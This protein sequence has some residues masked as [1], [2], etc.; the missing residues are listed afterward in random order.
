V[1][2]KSK[3]VPRRETMATIYTLVTRIPKEAPGRD[4]SLKE[5]WRVKNAVQVLEAQYRAEANAEQTI[6]YE[7]DP[8]AQQGFLFSIEDT[9]NGRPDHGMAA[10]ELVELAESIIGEGNI[11]VARYLRP[12][13]GGFFS[14]GKNAITIRSDMFAGDTL[15]MLLLRNVP[16]EEQQAKLREKWGSIV[17]VSADEIII[18]YVRRPKG[19]VVRVIRRNHT[20][21]AHAL[22]HE[23]GHAEDN[24]PGP[25]DKGPTMGR[26]RILGRIA[27]LRHFMG[28]FLGVVSADERRTLRRQAQRDAKAAGFDPKQDR[29]AYNQAVSDL[30]QNALAARLQE[31]GTYNEMTVG[32]I[33]GIRAE[34][35]ALTQWW[36][37]VTP[38][39]MD[40]YLK[41]G[42]E[43]YADMISVLLNQPEEFEARCPQTYRALGEFFAEHQEM[44]DTYTEI[45]KDIHAAHEG[46]PE[47][48][49]DRRLERLRR[50]MVRDED[51]RR[52]VIDDR[53][54]EMPRMSWRRFWQDIVRIIQA[55]DVVLPN[56]EA[57]MA[58]HDTHYIG[59]RLKQYHRDVQ[60]KVVKVLDD[61]GVNLAD[62][63]LFLSLRRAAFDEGRRDLANF[64]GTTDESAQ[65]ALDRMREVHG[66]QAFNAMDTAAE[67][68]ADIRERH[69]FPALAESGLV[70]DEFLAKLRANRY[71]STFQVAKYF[72]EFGGSSGTKLLYKQ[73]GSVHDIM[74]PFYATMATDAQIMWAASNNHAKMK[75]VEG[76]RRDAPGDVHEP[77]W[78]FKGGERVPENDKNPHLYGLLEWREGKERKA[79]IVPLAVSELYRHNPTVA[80]PA[81]AVFFAATSILK[82]VMTTN[83]PAFGLG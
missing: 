6:L 67:N 50:M 2:L 28:R 7:V 29:D 33:P 26:G 9:S 77:K 56:E 47:A 36:R 16:T 43:L 24:A 8:S 70:D 17:G 54:A 4:K 37:G 57:R 14:P 20:L 35:E 18:H 78:T 83:N 76:L 81:S 69:I 11:S 62:F 79:A 71:Y 49:L 45:Q 31:T 59:G 42:E 39:Q 63:G 23:I 73:F 5:F 12:D 80:G 27:K 41:S 10:P 61:A 74:N 30:Y 34:L 75:T 51:I 25:D 72:A 64:Q 66:D 1:Q 68:L 32:D 65:Q 38:D 52:K 44:R 40:A 82:R 19:Y 55:R 3:Q 21:A 60:S 13:L 48:L 15:T 58:F 22:A 46:N 53:N